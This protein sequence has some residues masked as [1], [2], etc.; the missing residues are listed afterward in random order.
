MAGGFS[1]RA[2]PPAAITLHTSPA[3]VPMQ[4]ARPEWLISIPIYEPMRYWF[5]GLEYHELPELAR[6]FLQ[7]LI[8]NH[9][10]PRHKLQ[11]L[12]DQKH[13]KLAVGLALSLQ[14]ND[15]GLVR[16][17]HQ[18]RSSFVSLSQSQADV[19][20]EKVRDEKRIQ[21]VLEVLIPHRKQ[22]LDD[23]MVRFD[24][25]VWCE[26]K[27]AENRMAKEEQDIYRNARCKP[28]I[29]GTN[30]ALRVLDRK[31]MSLPD[32]WG[33]GKENGPMGSSQENSE[34]N[35]DSGSKPEKY[36]EQPE[37]IG[38]WKHK[39]VGEAPR[40]NPL[41]NLNNRTDRR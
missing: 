14:G 15:G 9:Y 37:L 27:P 25:L 35:D 38:V 1:D 23:F 33:F 32:G 17:R 12:I 13:R 11:H 20:E 41:G 7:D 6:E 3:V 34:Q 21:E 30:L 18:A 28:V 19:A 29:D 5:S 39:G 10:Q 24:A 16:L 40:N 26:L 4:R 2:H 31:M 8:P 22:I 36:L